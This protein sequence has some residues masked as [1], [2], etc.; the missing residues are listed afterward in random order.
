M[1][2]LFFCGLFQALNAPSAQ[3]DQSVVLQAVSA[4]ACW[5][6]ETDRAKSQSERQRGFS[7]NPPRS[8]SAILFQWPTA[9]PRNFWM[10][11]THIPLLL[12]RMDDS[13]RTQTVTALIPLDETINTDPYQGRF[14]IEIRLDALNPQTARQL[15]TVTEFRGGPFGAPLDRKCSPLQ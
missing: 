11:D 2:F 8:I 3:S 10:K 1:I 13:G 15:T 6:V 4:D 9:Q 7:Q 14:A 5:H 12:F